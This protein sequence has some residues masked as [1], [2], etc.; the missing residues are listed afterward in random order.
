MIDFE[1]I[2]PE[3]AN[4]FKQMKEMENVE[5]LCLTF[6]AVVDN[7]GQ[8]VEKDIV[9]GGS[10]IAVTNENLDRFILSYIEWYCNESIKNQF[11]SFKNGLLTVLKQKYLSIFSPEEMDILVSGEEVFDW[12]ELEKNAKYSDGFNR[13]SRC[14][15]W[16]W[17]L[18]S[19]LTNDEK[20]KFLFFVTGTDRAP[21]GGLK[22]MVITI[23]KA[24]STDA[25]PVAHT[26]FHIL[27]LPDYRSEKI[28]R[29]KML[30]ALQNCE[31][32][33]LV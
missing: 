21:L 22:N 18:F 33:G 24:A 30:F 12:E 11:N 3:V 8:K 4:S 9:P 5:D 29:D 6:T 17:K 15:K 16:F 14:V 23:Q 10:E 1:E 31:G 28:L 7:F 2:E 25:L 32:F 26:C 13:N 19:T 27:Q 20:K